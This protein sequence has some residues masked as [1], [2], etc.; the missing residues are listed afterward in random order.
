MRDDSIEGIY[1]TLKQCA[2]ISKYAGGIG[3]S[4]HNIRATD[5]YIRGTNGSSNGIVPMLKVFSDTAHYVDQGGG[6][7]KGS[8]A[9][10]L[11]P[12]H[13]DIKS[14]L[15]LKKNTGPPRRRVRGCSACARF[16]HPC[17]HAGA[18]S[19]EHRARNLFYALWVP[20]LFMKRVQ[21]DGVWTL[22]CA[23]CRRVVVCVCVICLF[24][25]G[26]PACSGGVGDA[27]LPPRAARRCP[28]EC[29]GLSDVWGD[30]F[31]ALYTKYEAEGRG[32]ETVKA[33]KLW[34]HILESQVETGTPY[35]LFK[36]ACNR[37]SNQQHLGT[38]K[39]S[40]LCTEIIEYT[41]PDEVAVCNLASISLPAF[42]DEA[43]HTFDF[44][45]LVH[46]TKVV[47]KNLNKVIDVNVSEGLQQLLLTQQWRD[48]MTRDRARACAQ[49]YP[50][51]EA[52]NSN[53]RHRPVGLGVQGLADA[54]IMLRLPFD[55]PAA[56]ALNRD[57]FE[58]MYF[59]AL[60]GARAPC[61]A[62]RGRH[63]R[64]QLVYVCVLRGG[65]AA[66]CELAAKLGPYESYPGSPASRGILQYDMW[67]VT[68]SERWDWAGLKRDIAAHGLRNSL[69]LAPMPTASTA[70]I[71]GNNEGCEP[72]TTN[73]YNR[74]VL[75]GEFT[76]VNTHMLRDL[77][78]AGLWTTA[79]RNQL[80]AEGGS[81]QG[82]A[83][84]PDELKALYKTVSGRARLRLRPCV[85]SR[86]PLPAR[87]GVGDQAEGHY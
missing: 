45:R 52:R 27:P 38:I 41:S 53:M 3:L 22:M 85:S 51:P 29:P 79:V 17:V 15:D 62:A 67:G 59:G 60:T 30:A 47:T 24:V 25:F 57:I 50:L 80:I 76:I 1:D 55:S 5:S 72:Y 54:F 56:V 84:I 2:L 46:V 23:R 49:F 70:Q 86:A 75:A 63:A 28:H 4:I 61:A 74:R 31:D 12:W 39:S 40:N 36:D 43:S 32:R 35:I 48:A 78:E 69:L 81:I 21:D 42:V 16:L 26:W 11:E 10:Y 6:K 19:E 66:S 73:V 14:F 37:K 77:I 87:A 71:L 18:G 83:C 64:A 9:I 68:P 65:R 13:A 82:I 7:R 34:F 58:A 8:I 20:D 33:Q 44:A